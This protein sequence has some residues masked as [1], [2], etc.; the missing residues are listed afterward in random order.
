[1]Q[2]DTVRTLHGAVVKL[3]ARTWKPGPGVY[4]A[5]LGPEGWAAVVLEAKAAPCRLTAGRKTFKLSDQ[6]RLMAGGDD[7]YV[8]TEAT[9]H[10]PAVRRTQPSSDVHRRAL[11][12]QLLFGT[13]YYMS[14]SVV[15]NLAP[16]EHVFSIGGGAPARMQYADFALNGQ[17]L[18]WD[19]QALCAQLGDQPVFLLAEVGRR[20]CRQAAR[21]ARAVKT[22]N[23]GVP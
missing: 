9:R 12:L 13:T 2:L 21:L 15:G 19:A 4:Y 20:I 7:V 1:M 17:A 10:L 14:P 3:S 23:S 5:R 11:E 8:L 18:V 22:R 16:G 6:W